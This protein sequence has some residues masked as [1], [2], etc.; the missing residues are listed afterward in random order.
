M[1]LCLPQ[2]QLSIYEQLE[3]FRTIT[4]NKITPKSLLGSIQGNRD[5]LEY[6]LPVKIE[7]VSGKLEFNPI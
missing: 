1:Y 5:Y 4:I 3:D 7:S 2:N 6:F